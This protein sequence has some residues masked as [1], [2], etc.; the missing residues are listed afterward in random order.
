MNSACSRFL[1]V[2]PFLFPLTVAHLQRRDDCNKVASSLV[3][4]Q[5]RHFQ[6]RIT[7]PTDSFAGGNIYLQSSPY[8]VCFNAPHPPRTRNWEDVQRAPA[9]R[10]YLI[11]CCCSPQIR[12]NVKFASCTSRAVECKCALSREEEE[13]ED[14]EEVVRL[15]SDIAIVVKDTTQSSL[16]C[17]PFR[18]VLE[19]LSCDINFVADCTCG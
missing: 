19:H 15:D 7:P 17:F 10:F 5:L 3:G 4:N 16:A 11:L 2:N 13:G 8:L 9:S 14:G 12:A 18:L 1:S 6:S